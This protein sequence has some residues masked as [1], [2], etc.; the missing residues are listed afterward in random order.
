LI[1]PLERYFKAESPINLLLLRFKLRFV[2]LISFL[3][4]VERYF[5]LV[6]PIELWL[7]SKDRLERLTSLTK[8]VER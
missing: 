6:F 1:N 5:A 8:P 2:R 4:E 7:R 3:K